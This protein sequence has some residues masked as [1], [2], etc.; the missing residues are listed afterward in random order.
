MLLQD[1][2]WSTASFSGNMAGCKKAISSFALCPFPIPY[3]QILVLLPYSPY[4]FRFTFNNEPSLSLF[5]PLS[6]SLLSLFFL[7]R[8][9][10]IVFGFLLDKTNIYSNDCQYVL[11]FPTAPL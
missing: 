2:I 1:K 3:S 10:L 11:L 8:I 5:V 6:P 9:R 7:S 4:P